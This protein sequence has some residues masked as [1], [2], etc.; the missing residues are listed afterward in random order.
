MEK[1]KL[2]TKFPNIVS[3]EVTLRKTKTDEFEQWFEM[4]QNTNNEFTP[5]KNKKLS[6]EAGFNVLSKHYDRDFLKKKEIFLGIYYEG[7]LAGCA[8]IFDV[9][10]KV[11]MVTI[12]YSLSNAHCG[13]GIAT[14][15]V[16]I[17][18]DYLFR[19]INVNRIQAFVIPENTKSANVLNRNQFKKE[20]TIRKGNY[21]TGHGILDLDLFSM[22]RWDYFENRN[23]N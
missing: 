3:G 2:F 9:D 15:T 21:W 16:R 13:K 11:D 10:E 8:V 5:R 7:V 20:G 23:G 4:I 17:L 14:K 12:G 1:E 19:E 18:I 22:L 6:R